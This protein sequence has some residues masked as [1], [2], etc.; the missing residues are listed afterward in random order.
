MRFFLCVLSGVLLMSCTSHNNSVLQEIII[1]WTNIDNLL[2]QENNSIPLESSIPSESLLIS[3]SSDFL[4]MLQEFQKSD[5][6]LI[7]RRIPFSHEVKRSFLIYSVKNFPEIENV[8]KLSL[9]FRDSAALGD[10]EKAVEISDEIN[11]SLIN[12]LL[13]DGEAQRYINTSYLLL[14]IALV[15]FIMIIMLFILFLHRSLI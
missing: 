13:I 12:F 15:F 14:L 3:E 10:M 9:N 4:R 2:L 5:L 6:Y 7:Y 1:K 8:I 11:K